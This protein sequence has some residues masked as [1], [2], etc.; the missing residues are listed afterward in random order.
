MGDTIKPLLL[1]S[2]TVFLIGFFKGG[3]TSR[4]GARGRGGAGYSHAIQR[5]IDEAARDPAKAVSAVTVII[6]GD[7]SATVVP[8]IA[9]QG[10]NLRY[11]WNRLHEVSIPA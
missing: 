7:P 5:W 2:V 6:E 4:V 11:R 10:G 3:R 8:Q 1:S 9:A